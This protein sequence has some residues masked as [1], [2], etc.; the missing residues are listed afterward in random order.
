MQKRIL[1]ILLCLALTLTAVHIS[2]IAVHAEELRAIVTGTNVRIRS[3]ASTSSQEL[4]RVS[5]VELIVTGE[6]NN[7][8]A[9]PWYAVKYGNISGYIYG[10]YI[11]FIDPSEPETEPK[12]VPDFETQLASFPE[13][14]HSYLKALHSKYPNWIFKA[15]KLSMSFEAAVKGEDVFP[16]KLVNIS[17]D[18]VSWRSMG[19]GSYNW[20]TGQWANTSGGWAG[21]STE[22]IKYYMDPRNF[23]NENDIYMFLQQGYDENQ[24]AEG[25][26]TII[27][28]SFLANGYS[29]TEDTAF[30][31]SYANVI[32]EAAKQSG[33]SAYVLASTIILEQG[34]NGTSNLISGTTSYGKYYNFFN[35][36]ASGTTSAD[37]LINGLNYA[38]S[39]GW[40][41]R[42]A[43]IIG[44]AKFYATGYINAGQDTYFY[45]D[46]D[47]LDTPYYEHQYAQSIYDAHSSGRL[48]RASYSANT[49]TPLIFRIPVFTSLPE[50]ISEKPIENSKKNNYYLLDSSISGFS[51][52]KY[53]YSFNVSQDTLIDT[54]VPSGASITTPNK[55]PLKVGSN[56][57]IITVKAETGYT[58]DYTL[59]ITAS[60]ECMLTVANGVASEIEPPVTTVKKGDTN[61]DG[62]ITIVDLANVQKY[63]LNIINLTGDSFN[64]ADT[65][66]DG[67]ITIVDLANIQKHLLAI[68]TL[69]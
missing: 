30:G 56:K 36:K 39:Q 40:S 35:I 51:T 6:V 47:L 61:M 16:K 33:V 9:F 3:Q 49:E 13:S 28:G 11:K 62:K 58:R 46:F 59:N 15:D 2:R 37:V 1:S 44:G 69:N 54:T 63:L 12:P 4:T 45:K 29:D 10:Q 48:I 57:V 14:Y 7:G 67:K 64:A 19:S 22:V 24:T 43:A 34:L 65:N 26:Q 68:I 31:G 21:A 41:T 60:K 66:N 17:S 27:K 18:A 53:D 8:Q 32:L 25:V 52:Y 55:I 23:L 5:N 50:K 42:S 20:S 38:K